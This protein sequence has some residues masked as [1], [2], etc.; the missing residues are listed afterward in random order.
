MY[1]SDCSSLAGMNVHLF[2]K[3]IPECTSGFLTCHVTGSDLSDVRIQITKDGVPLVH[4]V[5]LT[6]PLPNGDGTVQMKLQA[7]LSLKTTEGY[8][9]Q[10]QRGSDTISVL[11]GR[12]L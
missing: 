8:R 3:Q 12:S 10:V 5:K 9:C 1:S 7:Q 2:I 11:S 4:R 6:G